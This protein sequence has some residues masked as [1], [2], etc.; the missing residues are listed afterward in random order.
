MRTIMGRARG[1][2]GG[3]IVGVEVESEERL[4]RL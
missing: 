2:G 4:E 3:G 1:G